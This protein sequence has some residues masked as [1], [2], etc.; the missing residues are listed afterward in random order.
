MPHLEE[1]VNFNFLKSGNRLVFN[2]NFNQYVAIH[3]FLSKAARNSVTFCEIVTRLAGFGT[4]G[5]SLFTAPVNAIH[6][7]YYH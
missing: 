5:N 2:F 4:A 1:I 6:I 7:S 3:C